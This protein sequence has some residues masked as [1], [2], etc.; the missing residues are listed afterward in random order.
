MGELGSG[1]DYTRFLEHLGVPALDVSFG[2]PYGVYHAV[3]D[4]FYWMQ[5]FGDPTFKYS[6]AAAQVYGTLALRLADAD[7]LPFDYEEYGKAIQ[8]YCRDLEEEL[9][10]NNLADKL[11]FEGATRAA[12]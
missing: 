12:A 6:V 4:T 10:K 1:S 8:K 9:K 3:Y 5:D 11:Q 7:I 2:G